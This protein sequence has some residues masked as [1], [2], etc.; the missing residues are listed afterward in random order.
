M[1]RKRS[2]FG[3][4]R[5]KRKN[6]V[7]VV[8]VLIAV[9]IVAVSVFS[10]SQIVPMFFGLPSLSVS[11][12]TIDWNPVVDIPTPLVI[13]LKD[14]DWFSLIETPVK[15]R[16][17]L[18]GGATW[19]P[20]PGEGLI[21]NAY[22]R[23]HVLNPTDLNL[24]SSSTIRVKA[25][26]FPPSQPAVD[27]PPLVLTLITS[28]QKVE[29]E[30]ESYLTGK[31]ISL[32]DAGSD[33]QLEQYC[34]C[35]SLDIIEKGKS[36]IFSPPT[37][38]G[39]TSLIKGN[40]GPGLGVNKENKII[41]Q[42]G[43]SFQ[44]EIE[45]LIG[46]YGP[47]ACTTQQEVQSTQWTKP[48]SGRPTYIEDLLKTSDVDPL[49]GQTSSYAVYTPRTYDPN[50]Q[51]FTIDPQASPYGGS[52]YKSDDYK[53]KI[54]DTKATNTI[55]QDFSVTLN[56]NSDG[57]FTVSAHDWPGFKIHKQ[58]I[59]PSFRIDRLDHFKVTIT[60]L[61]TCICEFDI[62]FKLPPGTAELKNKN[63]YKR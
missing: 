17:S 19:Y 31:K 49:T 11:I 7:F 13:E 12:R 33:P 6:K 21:E 46:S 39:A 38:P 56:E 57:T 51:E 16:Y 18:D 60:G 14:G 32:Q 47:A 28:P 50:T 30:G 25:T 20:L 41:V 24:P 10:T 63:C 59:I 48:G 37:S 5:K 1:I 29:L 40:L 61:P 62:E 58:Y 4:F 8:P 27:S 44:G 3:V 35:K 2:R 55:L 42:Y 53:A 45:F 52:T 26:A 9:A 22:E 34:S 43:F 54:K 36:P 23:T 15:V